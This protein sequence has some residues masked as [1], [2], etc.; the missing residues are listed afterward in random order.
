VGQ[1]AEELAMRGRIVVVGLLLFAASPA[2]AEPVAR[3]WNEALLG[4]VRL[5][6]PAPTVRSRN[7]FHLSAA[8]YDAWAAYDPNA[9]GYF[10][11][12]TATATDVEAAPAGRPGVAVTAL[13]GADP[14]LVRL[15]RSATSARRG[16]PHRGRSTACRRSSDAARSARNGLLVGRTMASRGSV[17]WLAHDD[18][19][20]SS[21]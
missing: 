20:R 12:E 18:T 4:A 10:V 3:Q 21:A 11:D 15:T 17:A 2:Q 1:L 14:P 19:T 8:M 5:D 9:Q 13:L 7:L 16:W 6:Y